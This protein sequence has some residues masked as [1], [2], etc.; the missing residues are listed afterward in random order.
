VGTVSGVFSGI[1]NFFSK[2]SDAVTSTD[3]D[4]DNPLN[5]ISGQSAFKRE[6]AY[7][8]GIDPYTSFEPLQKALNDLA[9]TA[10]AGGLT[11][12][13]AMMAVPGAA[14]AVVSYSGTAETMKNLV[15]DK[16]PAEL[17][18]INRESLRGMGVNEGLADLFLASTSYSP[19]EKTFL[20]GALAS[21]TGVSDRSIFI[22]LAAMDC[23][24]SVALFQRVRAQLMDL[25]QEKARSVEKFVS[26]DGVPMM[27][28]KTGMAVGVFP[29]DYVGW[30]VGFARKATGVSNT[31]DAMPGI[32][33]KELW[34]TGTIDPM[35]RSVLEKKGWKLEDRIQDRL[36]KKL[37]P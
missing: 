36:L 29:L 1:G 12:K 10:A 7:Q 27:L 6:Y 22:R 26:A 17:E 34:I 14:G 8:F 23:E 37:E 25:Y 33:G 16:T 3:P 9:W 24:E 30:T 31:I 11:V 15:R 32:K 5:A 19:R 13:G 2:V 21:M 4:K 35:A 18:K 20:V 28:T